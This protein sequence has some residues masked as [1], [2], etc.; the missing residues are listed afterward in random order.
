MARNYR[1]ILFV[2]LFA[3]LAAG[4]VMAQADDTPGTERVSVTSR[5]VCVMLAFS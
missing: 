5:P 1:S 4:P 2:P 3:L